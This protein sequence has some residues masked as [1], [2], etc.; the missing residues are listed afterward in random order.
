MKIEDINSFK[1]LDGQ[2]PITADGQISNG[3]VSVNYS[4]ILTKLIQEAGR[5]CKAYAS[6]L[7]VFWN[8]AIESLE[9]GQ[10]ESASYLF[11]FY[12]MGVDCER[13]IINYYKANNHTASLRYRAIWRLDIKVNDN[14]R[15]CEM[16]LY[17]V[18]R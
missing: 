15:F 18:Y 11:G 16:A 8:A 2:T 3:D 5:W 12:E 9:N 4:S 14:G 6:D 17:E 1:M 7:F 13:S 10:L